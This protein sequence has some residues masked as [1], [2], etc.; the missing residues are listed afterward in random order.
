MAFSLENFV[1]PSVTVLAVLLTNQLT[2]GRGNK[3]KLWELRRQAYGV[4]LS[5]LVA[6]ER[7][8]GSADRYIEEDLMRYYEGD[9]Y[10]AHNS[11][12]NDHMAVA[13]NRF[14]S[15]YL[16]L[17]DDFLDIFDGFTADLSAGWDE[18]PPEEYD[19]F[20]TAV[21]A[22]RPRL[23]TQARREMPFSQRWR[24]RFKPSSAAK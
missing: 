12:I 13:R 1:T 2:Y 14:A 7:I 21:R 3:E 20:A 15:D 11:N 9:L 16:I 5:E 19:R 8:C 22:R 24:R 17:S 23:A 6:V 10:R 18:S 4:I